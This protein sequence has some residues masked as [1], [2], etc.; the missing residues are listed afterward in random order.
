MITALN[1]LK[2]Q[3]KDARQTFT[4]TVADIKPTHL[5]KQPGGKALPLAAVYAHLFFSEDVI[6]H[7][8]MQN[9]TPLFQ[10]TW[11]TKTGASQPMPDMDKNWSKNHQKWAQTV[12]LD[13]PQFVKYTRAVSRATDKYIAGLKPKDLETK[14]DLGSW[15][16]YTVAAMLSGWIIG[17][18]S[19]LTGEI[20]AV[21][22]VHGAKGYPF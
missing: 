14:I 4:D 3:L 15:G 11:K 19:C 9:Q 21:K 12:K 5:H 16:K 6:I 18:I 13:L 1:L 2:N 20:S 8:L 22:G 10:S 7:N 17:H